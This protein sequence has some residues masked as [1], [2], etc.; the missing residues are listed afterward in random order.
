MSQTRLVL[1]GSASNII[2]LILSTFIA[3]ILPPFLVRHLLP[4]EYS[5]WVLILQLSAYVN[6]L[7]F[8]LQTALSKFVA[9][10]HA[11]G[12]KDANYRLV[13]TSII[14]LL[15]AAI[16]GAGLVCLMVWRVPQLFHQMPVALLHEVRLGLLMVGL[17]AAFSLPFSP[18]LA[19]FIGLQ[20]YM[21]PT[22]VTSVSRILSAA[23]LIVLLLFHA[24]LTQ[25]AAAIAICNLITAVAQ[26]EVWRRY[27]RERV[28]VAFPLFDRSSAAK[29]TKF[30]GA[31]AI[32]ALGGLCVSGLDTVIV[33]H[34]DYSNTGFYAV[35]ASAVNFLVTIVS[36]VFDPL[37]PSVSSLQSRRLPAQIG[38]IAIRVTRYCT[39]LLCGLGLP[40]FLGAFPLLRLWVGQQYAAA[41]TSF[42]QILLIGNLIRL[43]LYPYSLVIVA[44]GKQHL[45]TVA[46]VAEAVVNLAVSIW[47]AHK[48][49][50]LGVAIGT[51]VGSS[52]SAILNL[53]VSMDLSRAAL[54][55]KRSRFLLQ[56]LLRPLVCVIPALL[57]YPFWRRTEMLPANPLALISWVILTLGIIW[58]VGLNDVER[59]Q[60]KSRFQRYQSL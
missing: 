37:I 32:W 6:L 41:S 2:R 10:H 3:F 29:L 8:G 21:I 36:N 4:A 25:L 23:L 42:L 56:G 48:M 55:L 17:S 22:A 47:L 5:A 39:L 12:D 57:F 33:G 52:V 1:R 24:R 15:T 51:I 60:V 43:L 38:D 20:D 49:G 31:V 40:L 28:A 54:L 30:G 14:A 53:T 18:F 46:V 9:E 27:A 19:V 16:I 50:A 58:I 34:F 26:W 7:D 45:A 13:S 11:T 59:K 44:M 35:G